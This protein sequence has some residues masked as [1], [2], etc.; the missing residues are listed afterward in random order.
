MHSAV[1]PRL[2]LVIAG[3]K[4]NV[5]WMVPVI[6]KEW[7]IKQ[8]G[9]MTADKARSMWDAWK[10]NVCKDGRTINLPLDE[11]GRDILANKQAMCRS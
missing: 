2:M 9:K 5:H 11:K 1:M 7:S 6:Q 10:A 8:K 3:I 4:T